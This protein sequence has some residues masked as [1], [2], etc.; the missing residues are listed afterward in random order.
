M[1]FKPRLDIERILDEVNKNNYGRADKNRFFKELQKQGKINLNKSKEEEEEAL[2]ESMENYLKYINSQ[3]R[4]AI[5][6]MIQAKTLDK[7]VKQY[8]KEEKEQ[9]I[10]NENFDRKQFETEKVTNNNKIEK[11]NNYTKNRINHKKNRINKSWAKDILRDLHTRTY[12]NATNIIANNSILEKIKSNSKKEDDPIGIFSKTGIHFKKNCFNKNYSTQK[13]SSTNSP[14]NDFINEIS[15]INKNANLKIK[16]KPG[17]SYAVKRDNL[18]DMKN[19]LK[20]DNANNTKEFNHF[21]LKINSE[22]QGINYINHAKRKNNKS[23]SLNFRGN[24]IN[25]HSFQSNN[26]ILESVMTKFRSSFISETDNTNEADNPLI[27]NMKINSIRKNYLKKENYD[28]DK[29][30]YLKKL[31]FTTNKKFDNKFNNHMPR[32]NLDR[33]P[34]NKKNEKG[35]ELDISYDKDLVEINNELKNSFIPINANEN[36]HNLSFSGKKKYKR[37]TNFKKVKLDKNNLSNNINLNAH[38]ST[39][40]EGD[41]RME[42]LA[43]MVVEKCKFVFKK[44]KNNN[45]NLISGNGK[46]MITSG[47]TVNEFMKKFKVK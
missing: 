47:L 23:A 7:V 38:F 8:K 4:V 6:K 30:D 28:T 11:S 34:D 24:Q 16:T 13:I 27:Y 18:M 36:N 41:N 32:Y 26:H 1:R 33:A 10:I 35:G 45:T 20:D 14:K 31:A 9:K 2:D 43:K 37:K 17:T 39:S 44:H 29:L 21:E 46:L 40:G 22:E 25:T 3:N 5:M 42:D 15:L 19:N 12:F